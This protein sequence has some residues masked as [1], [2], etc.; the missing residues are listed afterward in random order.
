M[1]LTAPYRQ[2]LDELCPDDQRPAPRPA[3]PLGARARARLHHVAL[4]RRLADGA[5]TADDRE[6]TVR[7]W[8]ITRPS[9]RERLAAALDRVLT[10]ASRPHPRLGTPVPICHEEVEVSRGEIVRLAARLRDPRPVHPRGVALL[11]GLLTD[12]T[13]PLYVWCPNDELYRRLRRASFAL[14]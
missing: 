14:D 13:G 12:G 2:L 9:A 11:R 8:Q 6:L 1:S 7:A 4:D 5:T 3:P 10:E